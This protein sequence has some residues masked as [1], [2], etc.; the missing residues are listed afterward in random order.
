MIT[1]DRRRDA[2]DEGS[3][4]GAARGRQA[5]ARLDLAGHF[6]AQVQEPAAA[7]RQAD[8]VVRRH[9]GGTPLP[10]DGAAEIAEAAQR[11][12][13]QTDCL[14]GTGE[15]DIVTRVRR[16]VRHAFQKMGVT[17]RPGAVQR[18]QDGGICKSFTNHAAAA[19]GVVVKRGYRG[20]RHI[21]RIRSDVASHT[22]LRNTRVPVVPPK[23]NELDSATSI[24]M[25]RASLGLFLCLL[26]GLGVFWLLVGGVTWSWFVCLLLLV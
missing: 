15:Q 14:A 21:M 5:Q 23:P 2:G 10:V 25:L 3:R 26:L 9:L 24:F 8:H 13:F 12:R 19:S 7:K 16:A 18:E 11:R 6:I 1:D 4:Q 22:S 17:R 20:V